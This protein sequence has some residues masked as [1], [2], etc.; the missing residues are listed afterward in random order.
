VTGGSEPAQ[1]RALRVMSARVPEKAAEAMRDCGVILLP[2]ACEPTQPDQQGDCRFPQDLIHLI[3]QQ[4]E[5]VGE[6]IPAPL[7]AS[8][9]RRGA[10][11]RFQ[12]TR[13]LPEGRS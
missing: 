10:R 4:A 11:S 3:E 7:L 2:I 8:S 5:I 13:A 12:A 1:G 6:D 9:L